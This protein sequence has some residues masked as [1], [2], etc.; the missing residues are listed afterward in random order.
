MPT[1]KRF[2]EKVRLFAEA[3]SLPEIRNICLFVALTALISPNLEEFLIYYNESMGVTPL[4]EGYAMVVLFVTGALIFLVYSN[5]VASK[6][7][8]HTTQAFAIVF[9][10]LSA[11]FFAYD[12]AGK[13]S[14]G[15]T[16]MIQAFAIR[17][18]VDAFLYL[19][20]IILYSKMVPHHIEGMMIGF[21]WSLIK[22]NSDVLG[23]LITVGLNQQFQVQGEAADAPNAAS[24]VAF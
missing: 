2:K 7:E 11:L 12:V 10:V 5:S 17:S 6:S 24:E 18:V 20:C 16:L 8:V 1:S 19:P 4:Y 3:V 15:K 23:R 21:I 22:L 13:Y 14:P 9:R